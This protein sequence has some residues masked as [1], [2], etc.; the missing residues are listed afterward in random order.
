MRCLVQACLTFALAVGVLSGCSLQGK[1]AES[2]FLGNWIVHVMLPGQEASLFIVEI[3]EADGKLEG[4]VLSTG[5]GIIQ[6]MEVGLEPGD[7]VSISCPEIGELR[8]PVARV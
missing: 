6:P 4:T 8:N 1:A 2:P 5:T 7:V 3:K